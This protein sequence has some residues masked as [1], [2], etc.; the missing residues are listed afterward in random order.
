MAYPASA[1]PTYGAYQVG[2]QPPYGGYPPGYGQPS[3]PR[4]PLIIGGVLAVVIAVAVTLILVLS[5]ST[6]PT[7]VVNSWLTAAQDKNISRLRDL[8]CE[9]ARD[10][11]T[12]GAIPEIKSWDITNVSESGDTATVTLNITVTVDGETHTSPARL[13]LIKENGDWKVCS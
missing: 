10:E 13:H 5:G 2:G 9:R 12:S 6:G 4:K 7:G 1:P 8:S 3:I 11:I